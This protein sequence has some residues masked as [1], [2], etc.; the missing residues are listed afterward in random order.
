MKYLKYYIII[1]SIILTCII[2]YICTSNAYSSNFDFKISL[3]K[4]TFIEGEDIFV[5]FSIENKGKEIDSILDFSD[6]PLCSKVEINSDTRVSFPWGGA[7]E[8]LP[9]YQKINPGE[10]IAVDARVNGFRGSE[11]S[12]LIAYFPV[13]K[14]SLKG[15][16][17][18]NSGKV[19]KSNKIEFNIV[20]PEGNEIKAFEDLIFFIDFYKTHENIRRTREYNILLTDRAIE[21]LYKYPTSVYTGKLLVQSY[22]TRSYGKYKYDESFLDDIE[23]YISNNINSNFN[24]ALLNETVML[25]H[26]KLGAKEKAKEYLINLKTKIKNNYTEKLIDKTIEFNNNLK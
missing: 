21:F 8:H 23:Y 13:G 5:I 14:Y 2:I 17:K 11:G 19:Y 10:I 12:S 9:Y 24:T 1:F 16:N 18:D 4:N 15:V 20:K 22:Y 7:Y 3:E 25:F 26:E 6:G